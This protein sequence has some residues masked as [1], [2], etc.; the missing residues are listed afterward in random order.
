MFMPSPAKLWELT[1]AESHDALIYGN[2][3][4]M[5]D[6]PDWEQWSQLF[7]ACIFVGHSDTSWHRAL[8][9]LEEWQDF[10]WSDDE[11]PWVTNSAADLLKDSGFTGLIYQPISIVEIGN[12]PIREVTITEPLLYRLEMAEEYIKEIGEEPRTD[13]FLASGDGKRPAVKGTVIEWLKQAGWR[14]YAAYPLLWRFG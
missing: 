8:A 9:E 4:D 3:A 6:Q 2:V 11:F 14:N 7:P 5:S 10:I 13:F 1:H 12:T